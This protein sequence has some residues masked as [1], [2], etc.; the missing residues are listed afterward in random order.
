MGATFLPRKMVINIF[1]DA[2]ACIQ[3]KDA[4]FAYW[5]DCYQFE[6]QYAGYAGTRKIGAAELYSI[7]HSL[8]TLMAKDLI[9]VEKINIYTDS[10]E[11]IHKIKNGVSTNAFFNMIEIAI[12]NGMRP[13][14]VFDLFNIHHIKAHTRGNDI[15]R[16]KNRWCDMMAKQ[17]R[18]SKSA[19][20]ATIF[21]N[22]DILL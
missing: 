20:Q 11:A 14:Q 16:H 5:I 1:S 13:R 12:K 4:G 8:E 21:D 19:F 18:F 17:H 7:N 22:S 6:I 15:M 10:T 2:S 9:P 3:S